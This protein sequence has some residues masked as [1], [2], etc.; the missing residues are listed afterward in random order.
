MF[1]WYVNKLDHYP[2]DLLLQS[3]PPSFLSEPSDKELKR[4][5]M[6]LYFNFFF[7][8]THSVISKQKLMFCMLS[9]VLVSSFGLVQDKSNGI[10]DPLWGESTGHR[11]IPVTKDQ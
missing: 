7:I 8:F 11:C 3:L 2:C 10:T 4:Y 9:V 5:F 6:A 1:Y